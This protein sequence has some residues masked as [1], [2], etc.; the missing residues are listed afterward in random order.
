VIAGVR[1]VVFDMAG[2]TVHDEGLVLECFVAA[3]EAVGLVVTRE[4][5]NERMGLSKHQ[6]FDE[7]ARRQLGTARSKEAE[8]LRDN[9]YDA[10]RRILEAS[11]ERGGVS[12]VRGTEA[13]FAW[14]RR[15]E[16]KIALNTG[17]YQRVTDIIVEKLGWRNTVDAVVCV[18]DVREGRPTPYMIHEAMQRCRVHAVSEVIVVGDTPS[19]MIAGFN[20]GARA[21]VGVTSGAHTGA[22][23][24]RFPATHITESVRDLPHIIERLGRIERSRASIL[25]KLTSEEDLRS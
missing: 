11:Y 22:S 13:V 8:A 3:A 10:F 6:V 18:D 4:E 24:R 9:G 12:Q 23:L 1:L 7:L 14:L 5:L 15:H 25:D 2:T 16:V 21:V 20:S 19:D 17:F